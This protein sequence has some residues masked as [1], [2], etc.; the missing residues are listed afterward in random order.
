MSKKGETKFNYK[1]AIIV[2]IIA[3]IVICIVSVVFGVMPPDALPVNYMGAALGSLLG[4]LITLVLLR[5]QTDI[6]E[7]KGKDIKILEKKAEVFQDYIK[8]VWKV[9]EDQK[10]TIEEFQN[11]T[12]KY[13]QNLMIYLKKDRL[14]KI[15][16]NLS[17]M[18]E[19][20][21]K[22]NY[23]DIKGLR[24][25]IIGVINELSDELELGG[26]VNTEIMDEHDRIVF[27]LI[28]KNQILEE[29]NKALPTDT[30]FEKG[31]FEFI[32]EF[33]GYSSLEYLCFDFIKYK[34][35][36]IVLN[37]FDGGE[38]ISFILFVDIN[39]HKFDD[40][41]CS[42]A[43]GRGYYVNRIQ[44]GKNN[45]LE[46]IEG[47]KDAEKSPPIN[48]SNKESMEKYRAEKR[49]FAPIFANRIKYHFIETRIGND[50]ILEFL[51]KHYEEQT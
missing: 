38:V 13:Y 44:I 29:A 46:P 34:G 36:R 43:G 2:S 11:L 1:S 30:I 32:Q 27:P 50:N 45:L 4:A 10:I 33:K 24:G 41:R 48:F 22:S 3:I 6:E 18:G 49:G 16:K 37:G 42:P 26:Q 35:C 7:K 39:Y 21:G 23:E 47:E 17:E 15:G 12:S 14:D 28:F 20:I 31:K 8:D 25:S 19:K 5:G 40:F 51:E 9:W